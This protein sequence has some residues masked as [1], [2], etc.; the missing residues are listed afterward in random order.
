MRGNMCIASAMAPHLNIG[1]NIFLVS[2]RLE[3]VYVADC[4]LT[5]LIWNDL[6][7]LN[8]WTHSRVII[9]GY[10]GT[11]LPI[12]AGVAMRERSSVCS[13]WICVLRSKGLPWIEILSESLVLVQRARGERCLVDFGWDVACSRSH[14]GLSDGLSDE[15]GVGVSGALRLLSCQSRLACDLGL[16]AQQGGLHVVHIGWILKV[17]VLAHVVV[18]RV[19]SESLVDLVV[20]LGGTRLVLVY[21]VGLL[22]VHVTVRLTEPKTWSVEEWLAA[23]LLKTV[24]QFAK[25]DF[26]RIFK[27][28]SKLS[29]TFKLL[30]S[31]P[32]QT[33]ELSNEYNIFW[34][35]KFSHSLNN[36][37]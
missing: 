30:M 10:H 17:V 22:V 20:S 15:K 34:N 16:V 21:L 14:I 9:L 27:Y 29:E 11:L 28:L 24:G 8:T 36:P 26:N 6:W 18:L 3:V 35:F 25:D 2:V 37:S 1:C 33:F 23:M 4:G 13:Y 32:Q 5:H 19:D 7:L 12:L 31:G